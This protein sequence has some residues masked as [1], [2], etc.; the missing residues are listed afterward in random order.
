MRNIK[1][2]ILTI[3]AALTTGVVAQKTY[4]FDDGVALTTDWTVVD[5]TATVGGNAIHEIASPSKFS[6]K[7]GKYLYFGFENK[8]GIT[9]SVTST[10]SYNN[11][12]NITFDA[13]AND[14]SK[15]SWT[16]DIVDDA[17][18]V[19][20]NVYS[21]VG[22]K[23]RFNTGGTNKWGVSN[24]N[25]SPAVSGH[26]KL[27]LTASSSG[28]YAAIDNLAITYQA[29]P[30]TDATLK[31]LKYNGVSVPDFAANK[32]EYEV[33]LPAGTTA[34][35]TVTAEANDA[36]VKSLVITQ[37]TALPGIAT[38]DVTAEDGETT[39]QYKVTFTVETANPKVESATWANIRGTANVDN[40]NMTITGQVLHGNSLTLEPQ[41][42]GK[43]LNSWGPTGAQNFANGAIK[44]TFSSST[45][46]TTDYM[47]TIT[48]APAMSSDATLKSLTYG[49]TPV[50]GFSPTTYVYDI[51][52]ASGTTTP[53][54]IAAEA[55][56]AKATVKIT[57]AQSVPGVGKVDVT[58]E[59]D[60]P[61]QYVVNFTV[62]VPSSDLIIH[63]PGLYESRGEGGYMT[64]LTVVSGREY[65]V[66]YTERTAEGDYPTF[67]TAP[68]A[69]GK[70]SGISGSTSSTENVGRTGDKWFR[71]TI[72]SHSECKNASSTGEFVFETKAIREHRLS[73][74]NTYQFHIKGYDQFSLWG[75]DKKI[76]ASKNIY[77]VFVVKVDGVEQ[78]IDK[79][80]YNKDSYTVR[81]Y[82]ISSGE[83]LI[84]V[85]TSTSGSNVCYMG[86]FSL[87][88]AQEPRV[89]HIVGNDSTQRVLQTQAIRPITYFTKYNSFGETKIIWDGDEA[90]GLSLDKKA[91]T[92]IGD[93]LVL[94][95]N[96]TCP[97]GVYSFRVASIFNGRETFSLPVKLTV[98]AEIKPDGATEG[99]A[100]QGEEMDPL[101][102]SYYALSGDDVTLTWLNGDPNGITGKG[103]NGLYIISGT[104]QNT[105]TF[106][107]TVSVKDGNSLS[108]KVIVHESV[109]A[110]VLYLYKNTDAY[111]EDGIY[112][113]LLSKYTIE[114]RKASEKGLR[115]ADQ[116]AKYKWIL[117]S[118]DAD[119]DNAEVLE[120]SRKGAANL[121]V[122]SMKAFAYAP[123]RLNWGEPNNGSLTDNARSITVQRED[124]PIF[125]ALNKKHGDKIPI[126]SAIDRKG[127]MPVAVNLQGSLCLATAFT[128]DINDYD[129]DG[130]LQ[131]FLHE[132]PAAMSGRPKY[133]CLPIAR[134]SSKNL[135]DDGKALIDQIVAYLLSNEASVDIPTTQIT[136][137]TIDGVNGEI[138]Q[139]QQTIYFDL[140]ISQHKDLDL[141]A[142]QPE[143]EVADPVYTHVIPSAEEAVDFSASTLVPVEYVVTDYINRTVYEVTIHTYTS[144]G[145]EDVYVV[146]EWVNIFDIYGRKIAT[147]NENIYT[148]DLPRGVYLIVNENGKTAKIF[149]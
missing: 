55:N 122:L 28:K 33:E 30:S 132:I 24:D 19:V 90:T 81:R 11:I 149:K 125:K 73:S 84:E 64:N 46:E 3:F 53:P 18:N 75:M 25:I 8:S 99:D 6:A 102:F 96:A 101:K 44:Y 51:E 69:E 22:A 16:L 20:K 130:E 136:R 108:G 68:V 10:A 114:P 103:E 121:P 58:A 36:A 47:I 82:D 111:K 87:R 7:D 135:T 119:A 66:F 79:S 138:N 39:K 107:F 133:I 118:E 13:V 61:L 145:I 26:I 93:T 80:L 105:G 23:D 35:P 142:I 100:Y 48:E 71:G 42:T 4:T 21:A 49:G 91:E 94:S 52:L 148:M 110:D 85:T 134:A 65:E 29:G 124:H 147:T 137:F 32:L 37:A 67:S 113:Y 128:R 5:N 120:I 98:R 116:Y 77:E 78:P 129:G 115:A 126:L 57:Q 31:S 2:F 83:H 86:G 15:P 1:F 50:P 38:V 95:G 92:S 41:F 131:T 34:V 63:T 89:S 12:S 97:A 14:N 54:T 88:V 127:L 60:T 112:S 76:D 144:E 70:T 40:V 74:S 117:I 72:T 146:G 59:D 104:P 17:G 27:T 140:D 43:Y 139:T 141:K 106:D 45:G 9:I 109:P 123:G 62:A 56:D 143:I